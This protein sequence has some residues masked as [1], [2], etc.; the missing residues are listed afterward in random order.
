MFC[1]KVPGWSLVEIRLVLCSA[2]KHRFKRFQFAFI[3]NS[4]AGIF[5]RFPIYLMSHCSTWTFFRPLRFPFHGFAFLDLLA[6]ARSVFSPFLL[7]F[8]LAEPGRTFPSQHDARTPRVALLLLSPSLIGKGFFS[9][10]LRF[11]QPILRTTS[12]ATRAS[13]YL[14]F[15]TRRAKARPNPGE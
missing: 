3:A 14:S 10:F 8:G 13:L 9:L 1:V 6:F 2:I 4:P 11:R 7:R 15:S 5:R 12:A